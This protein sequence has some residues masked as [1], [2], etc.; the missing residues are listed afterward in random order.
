[1]FTKNSMAGVRDIL[2]GG[3][4]YARI[5]NKLTKRCSEDSFSLEV[6]LREAVS[7]AHVAMPV[8]PASQLPHYEWWSRL[9]RACGE[10]STTN[11]GS[12]LL[13]SRLVNALT[14]RLA[15]DEIY[16]VHGAEIEDEHIL[17]PLV[18]M[19]L[20]RSNGHLA[21]H[22]LA[23]SGLFLALRQCD[24]ISPSLLLDTERRDT[25]CK[26]LRG[27]TFLHPNFLSVR[28]PQSDQ[29]DDDLTLHLMTPQSHAWGLLHGL[30]A[31]LLQCL[32]E[33]QTPVYQQVKRTMQLF[34][35]YKRR[36]HF[37]EPVVR[38]RDPIN[39]PIETQRYGTKNRL[40]RPMW[41]LYSPFAILSSDALNE[42]F[43]DMRAIWVHRALSQC[44]PSLCSSLCLHDALY[45]GRPPTD[46]QLATMGEKVLGIFGSGTSYAI[47][48]YGDFEQRRMAHWSNRDVKRHASRVAG[49]TLEYFGIELD[50]YRRLQM[51][52]GQT[53][54][55][56]H[57]RPLHD[58]QLPYF[59]LHE[60][61]VG[62]VFKDYI[63]QFEE[64]AFEKRFGTTVEAYQPLAG[65][66]ELVADQ[67]GS[68][69]E[70]KPGTL[71]SSQSMMGHFLQGKSSLH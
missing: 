25:F 15:I 13:R 58:S 69:D 19:G 34:Q 61:V 11:L 48:F 38:E 3:N 18:V 66:S 49:K 2:R 57:F 51:I 32:D 9:C 64:F 27:F 31:Y 40:I 30:D 7:A 20:P 52:D 67:L 47:S 68:S 35:W 53:E 26:A 16:R 29:V 10:K 5:G 45:T 6:V 63:Y 17:Q 21:A 28:V 23:R 50:R 62:A 33:D 39:N 22:V 42:V 54:Y 12:Q 24:T 60:G 41:L 4:V 43:P 37:T 36:G 44:I 46:T 59:C 8:D 65:A 14:Q 71:A 55:T 56:V 1:M 70:K